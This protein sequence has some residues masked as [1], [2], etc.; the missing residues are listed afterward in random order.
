MDDFPLGEQRLDVSV[1]D[2]IYVDEFGVVVEVISDLFSDARQ[3]GIGYSSAEAD[4]VP[5]ETVLVEAPGIDGKAQAARH[6]EQRDCY[7]YEGPRQI[8]RK[9]GWRE[10]WVSLGVSGGGEEFVFLFR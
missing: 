5:V 2:G 3:F 7:D 8:G 1:D 4:V 6:Q 9:D 10:C